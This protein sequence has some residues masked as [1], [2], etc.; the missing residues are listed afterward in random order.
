VTATAAQSDGFVLQGESLPLR[1][2]L[3]D[4]W[5]SRSLIGALT[6]QSFYVRYRRAALG[7]IWAVSLPLL[8]AAV[9]A[10]VFSQMVKI[11]AGEHYLVFV[12]AGMTPWG[13]FSS[14]VTTATTSIVENSGMSTRIYFPRL[15]FPVVSVTSNL[16]GFVLSLVILVAASF[17]SGID[18]GLQLLW[19]IPAV[20]L[21]LGLTLAFS[22]LFSAM[23]V[24]FRD[25][26]FF[27]QAAF[28]AW[29][30]ATPVIYSIEQTQR[31][32]NILPF[33]PVT[34]VVL[35]FRA[36]VYG[37]D[38][39]FWISIASTVVWTVVLLVAGLVVH[40]RYDRLFSD[41]L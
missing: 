40:R 26:R 2:L 31:L 7:I 35:A 36:A 30:Y 9:L 4:V 37:S 41:L 21:L 20:V 19:L 15:V 8:Q 38:R 29:L 28:L 3:R 13:F 22:I 25:M 11:G 17:L 34:G 24:Y 1:T 10:F 18:P 39:H 6:R 5:R 14:G 33:N 16:Y 23:H 32:G 27:V 12:L